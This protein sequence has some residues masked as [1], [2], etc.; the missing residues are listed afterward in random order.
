M[1]YWVRC[2]MCGEHLP[3]PNPGK[4]CWADYHHHHRAVQYGPRR[5]PRLRRI[6]Y[7]IWVFV[8]GRW[9]GFP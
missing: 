1:T 3:W 9:R 6:G 7:R 4:P 2:K 8:F 5:E